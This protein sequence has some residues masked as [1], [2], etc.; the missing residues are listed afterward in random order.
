MSDANNKYIYF[1]CSAVSG[2]CTGSLSYPGPL[3]VTSLNKINQNLSPPP[4]PRVLSK[5]SQKSGLLSRSVYTANEVGDSQVE[6]LGD[7]GSRGVFP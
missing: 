3:C 6:V 2:P 1:P 4:V 7:G 5:R